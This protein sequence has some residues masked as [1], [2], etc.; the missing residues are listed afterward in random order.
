MTDVATSDLA[1]V[2]VVVRDALRFKRKLR[3]GDDAYADLRVKKAARQMWAALGAAKAGA[4]VAGSGVVASAFFGSSASLL[5]VFGLGAAAAT[6]VGWVIAAAVATGG[7]SYGVMQ[8]LARGATTR[9]D[10]IPQF[11]NTPLD[12]LGVQLFD[13]MGALALR[14]ARIDGMIVAEERASIL[15]HLS[16]EWGFASEYADGALAVLEN[17]V[18][19]TRVKEIARSLAQFQS[20]NPD[21]NS[22]LMQRELMQFLRDVIAADGIFDEREELAL[23]AIEATFRAERAMT[24]EKVGKSLAEIG[25]QAGNVVAG[26]QSQLSA[27]VSKRM[28]ARHP[29]SDPNKSMP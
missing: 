15:R 12:I 9:S 1:Q 29:A 26:L 22:E 4:A 14:V 16:G 19:D 28:N 2:E 23:D 8:L 27:T 25:G 21:C 6:P 24:V 3:I 10:V 11:I 5:S 17:G 7:A 20:A 18:D 13:L